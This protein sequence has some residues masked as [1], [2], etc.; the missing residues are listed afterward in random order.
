MTGHISSAVRTCCAFKIEPAVMQGSVWDGRLQMGSLPVTAHTGSI[1]GIP[2][3]LLRP[4]WGR[5]NLF[6]G[7]AIYGG[8]CSELEAYLF[9]SR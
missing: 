1:E 9:L 6:R 8:S 3:V 4:D 7:K 5:C 2:V